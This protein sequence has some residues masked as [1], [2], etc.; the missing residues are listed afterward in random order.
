[1]RRA[2][3]PPMKR[4]ATHPSGL[5]LESRLA[6]E[7]AIRDSWLQM[8]SQTDQGEG[9]RRKAPAG[10][11]ER[12]P[13]LD[14]GTCLHRS[15]S[16]PGYSITVMDFGNGVVEARAVFVNPQ[17]RMRSPK[18]ESIERVDR[19]LSID[20]VEWRAK[21]TKRAV[22][23]RIL[24]LQ[25][26]HMI[27]LTKRGKFS[28]VDECREAW[29]RFYNL[30]L[31]FPGIAFRYV[32]VPERHADGTFHLH[33]A[34][35]GRYDVSFLR[36]LWYRALGGSGKER[37]EDT[38]GSINIRYLKGFRKGSL[39]AASYMSKYMSKSLCA[40]EPKKKLYWCTQG[41]TPKN[42]IHRY[43]EPVGDDILIRVRDIAAP[44][45]P[46]CMW[47]LFEWS[48]VGTHGFIMRTS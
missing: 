18:D 30:I 6:A 47:K 27:T 3:R 35:A 17:K 33:V 36:R 15:P 46:R 14:T 8:Q 7:A 21:R 24:A 28:T 4:S 16:L 32:C 38:P 37:G 29:R 41:L 39:V 45:A 5:S 31:K 20:Q 43:F 40:N 13:N 19:P 42:G 9:V 23:F 26:D 44:M 2:I 10:R 1:M 22:R 12:A 11:A 48:M 34:V 25:A